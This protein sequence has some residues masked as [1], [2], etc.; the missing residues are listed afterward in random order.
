MYCSRYTVINYDYNGIDIHPIPK[1]RKDKLTIYP[2]FNELLLEEN[3]KYRN[4]IGEEFLYKNQN[5]L[6]F[7]LQLSDYRQIRRF[8]K[9]LKKGKIMLKDLLNSSANPLMS[10]MLELGLMEVKSDL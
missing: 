3:R 2:K 10:A 9:I 8:F 4:I 6:R 7:E 5:L 1:T